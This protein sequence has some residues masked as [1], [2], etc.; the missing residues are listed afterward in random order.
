MGFLVKKFVELTNNKKGTAS[1]EYA[2]LAALLA[3][4]IMGSVLGVADQVRKNFQTTEEAWKDS[5]PT[6]PR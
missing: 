4:A 5:A 6:F 3:A 2:A 1:I